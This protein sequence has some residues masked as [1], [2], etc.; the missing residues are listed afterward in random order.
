MNLALVTTAYITG[1][2][3][4]LAVPAPA[5]HPALAAALALAGVIL[6]RARGA[7][8][9]LLIAL[10]ALGYSNF[11][12]QQTPAI[13]GRSLLSLTE[14]RWHT[15][16][17]RLW[18]MNPGPD[19]GERLDL[20]VHHVVQGHAPV[21][22]NGNL[23]LYLET[24][25]RRFCPG[26]ELAVRLRPR[27]PRRFGTPGEFNY[28]RHLAS[29][30][31]QATAFLPQDD[32]IVVIKKA[33]PGFSRTLRQTV[34]DLIDHSI[35]DRDK[36]NLAKALVV[37][38]KDRMTSEQRQRLAHLGL[39]HL[40]S[41]SGF[42]LGLVAMF[43]YLALLPVMR[44][45][46]TLLL[47]IPPRRL[48]PALLIPWLWCYLHITGQA[49]PTTRA[50][51]AAVAVIALCWL[52]RF[53]HPL[54]VALAVA[55]AILAATP[56]ALIAPSF[57]LSFAG[58]FGILILVPRW[59]RHLSVLPCW[60]R[61]ILQV[62]LVTLAATISTAPL[63]LWH[64][65]L[66][67]PAGLL[68]NL[69]AGPIIGGLAIPAGLAGLVLTPLW[70]AGAAGCFGLIAELLDRI[71][72]WSEKVLA[73]P[74]MAPRQL[75]LPT[76]TLV[77]AGMLVIALMVPRRKW[78]WGAVA[79]LG[80]ALLVQPSPQPGHLRVIALSVG[81][82]DALLVTDSAG[83]HYLVDGGGQAHGH[84][85]PGERLVA[86]ALGRFGVRELAAV[87]LTHD[88]PDHRNG[89]LHIAR[90]FRIKEFWCGSSASALWPPLR[91]QLAARNI[92]VRTFA[93]GWTP[94]AA[95]RKTTIAVFAPPD[96]DLGENDR[97]LVFYA[98][99]NRN[100]VLLTGDLEQAGVAHLLNATPKLPV[101]LLKLPHHGSRNG[102]VDQLLAHF[103]PCCVFASLGAN[104]VF[105][106]P[107]QETLQS[108]KRAG[109]SLWRTDLHG[110]LIFDLEN[111]SWR[112]RSWQDGLFR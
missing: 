48:L 72:D 16:Y 50:W 88:H 89:L 31:I 97:S 40:F 111:R 64:F 109:L 95:A 11:H 100:G 52:R 73:L 105:G 77:L 19:G 10:A 35:S 99:E 107:H 47:A 3:L 68:T 32:G 45:S 60:P 57:Q 43:G 87:I 9:L 86:P 112:V 58:V 21:P 81:Q 78:R 53:C 46:E 84:F 26:D 66:L 34:A 15:F 18:R 62:P 63:V 102:S 70:P 39:A 49:L 30:A 76:V 59:S 96:D 101:T 91:R 24:S 110:T 33:R 56:M 67:A 80:L 55:V 92:P 22:V 2:L 23:R 37:G 71:L 74:L 20:R 75:Y 36:A 8:C 12:L 1:L 93:P 94:V 41:I 29:E 7:A 28:P 54:R 104:N 51:L 27:R 38:D 69:W 44:R 4:A 83:Q 98:R 42:H 108:V 82:G 25:R 65:H 106:F 61:R 90:H 85:D 6:R 79:L 13:A 5:W 17:G 103:T 14:H